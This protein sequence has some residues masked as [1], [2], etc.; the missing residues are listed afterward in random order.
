MK[1]SLA[2]IVICASS[3]SCAH[4][5][6]DDTSSRDRWIYALQ[7]KIAK[8]V[9][10]PSGVTPPKGQSCRLE[11]SLRPDGV[12]LHVVALAPCAD[13]YRRPLENAAL[14]SMPLPLP[15]DPSV[16]IQDL[17]LNIQLLG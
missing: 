17:I 15:D 4:R 11:I 12:I 14:K 10:V 1:R 9:A 6:P 13:D 7:S 3:A 16:F 8:N 5:A 2:A